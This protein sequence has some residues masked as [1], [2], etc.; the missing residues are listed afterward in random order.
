MLGA[1]QVARAELLSPFPSTVPGFTIRN[2]HLV[3]DPA[4]SGTE[5][6]RGN[7][8]NDLLPELQSYGV[9]DVLIFK[10]QTELEVDAE[11]AALSQMGYASERIT[12]IPFVWKYLPEFRVSCEETVS[13]L[14]VLF[15]ATLGPPGTKLFLHCTVGEDRTGVLAGAFRMLNQAWSLDYAFKNELCERGYEKGN[16][17]KPKYVIDHIQRGLTPFFLKMAYLIE[18]GKLRADA[19]D[20]AVCAQDP[21]LDPL[22]VDSHYARPELYQCETSSHFP[23]FGP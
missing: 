13:A 21:A 6:L 23:G 15:R 3:N 17:Y 5:I 18:T 22:F 2:T 19:L 20:P 1:S 9:T 8:P 14:Q 7:A 16:P 11:L 10:K 4:L 12:H